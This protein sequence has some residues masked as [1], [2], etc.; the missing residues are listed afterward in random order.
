MLSA[1]VC[2]WSGKDPLSLHSS[3][4]ET[5]L[6]YAWHSTPHDAFS[7]LPQTATYFPLRPPPPPQDSSTT[8]L[9]THLFNLP[10]ELHDLIFAYT[11][12][13]PTA[14]T[15]PLDETYALPA[16]LQVSRHT[17]SRILKTYYHGNVFEPN[18]AKDVW[19]FSNAVPDEVREGVRRGVEEAWEGKGKAA[20]YL[21]VGREMLWYAWRTEGELGRVATRKEKESLD[22]RVGGTFFLLFTRTQRKLPALPSRL[23]LPQAAATM[24]A[25]PHTNHTYSLRWQLI[26]LPQELRDIIFSYTFTIPAGTLNLIN[27]NYKPPSILQVSHATRHRLLEPYYCRNAFWVMFTRPEDLVKWYLAQPKDW[28]FTMKLRIPGGGGVRWPRNTID[29][30][31][32]GR[33]VRVGEAGEGSSFE[34]AWE[35]LSLSQ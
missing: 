18:E 11:F 14:L 3:S 17:R 10:Q 5:S 6:R 12:T 29:L 31:V 27:K 25:T 4:D 33:L 7:Q 32:L 28:R 20:Y 19:R 26:R 15:I 13:P 34:T 23:N 22:G 21:S 1:E 35:K 16:I 2:A 9:R 30:E 8:L 24:A